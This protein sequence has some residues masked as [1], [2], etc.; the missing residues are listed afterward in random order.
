M[1]IILSDKL[2]KYGYIINNQIGI[3]INDNLTISIWMTIKL[4]DIR[5]ICSVYLKQ[6]PINC[7][8]VG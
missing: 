1:N 3:E 6:I 5:D 8:P 7:R 2:L 4:L